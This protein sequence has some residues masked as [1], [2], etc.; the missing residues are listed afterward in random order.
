MIDLTTISFGKAIYIIVSICLVVIFVVDTT[1]LGL[2]SRHDRA[3]QNQYYAF[4]KKFG[5]TKIAVLKL[6]IVLW[7]LYHNFFE[8]IGKIGAISI[9]TTGYLIV[10]VRLMIAY[11]KA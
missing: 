6:V 4:N 11:R 10:V 8:H 7:M 1:L 2:I 9:I 3:L 5:L